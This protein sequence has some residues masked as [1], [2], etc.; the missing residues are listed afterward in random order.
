MGLADGL[1]L[2]AIVISFLTFAI[3]T[4]EQYLKSA[5]LQVILG[6][7]IW[8]LG[9]RGPGSL[10]FWASVAI[11]NQGAVDAVILRIS[12][13]LS[14]PDGSLAAKV[15]WQA[16]G[17]YASDEKPGVA[18]DP[19]VPRFV[20]KDWTETLVASSRKAAT[21][22]ISFRILPAPDGGHPDLGS[23]T[24]YTLS[25]EVYVPDT[26]RPSPRRGRPHRGERLALDWSGSFHL[27]AADV[28]SL[29]R[30]A[31]AGIA[32]GPGLV[33]SADM[34]GTSRQSPVASITGRPPA[35]EFRLPG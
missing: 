15:E 22:W 8:L 17:G 5:K 24:T 34:T 19:M 28:A 2:V 32:A 23:D 7:Q 27:S 29:T 12:G 33:I 16:L 13:G 20:I 10:G 4:Y 3:T 35:N 14:R 25:L 9:G 26:R 11:V 31:D 30:Q 21:N 6:R 18:A 1:S